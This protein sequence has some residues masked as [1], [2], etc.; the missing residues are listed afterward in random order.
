MRTQFITR[1]A[2]PAATFARSSAPAEPATEVRRSALDLSTGA[3]TLGEMFLRAG[4][5]YG[6]ALR[7]KRDGGWQ[8]VSY[9]EL[10][11]S[12]RDMA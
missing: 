11:Q 8:S 12:T 5:R 7:H 3:E 2:E 1:L 4:E 9:Q 10:V 6:I